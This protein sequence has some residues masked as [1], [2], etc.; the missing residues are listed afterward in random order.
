MESSLN[1]VGN[2]KKPSNMDIFEDDEFI[3][4]ERRLEANS[5]NMHTRNSFDPG[6]T[7]FGS[8]QQ[9]RT[10][11]AKLPQIS[12]A[13]DETMAKLRKPNN[14]FFAVG[15]NT[16]FDKTIYERAHEGED[17]QN[18]DLVSQLNLENIPISPQDHVS[19]DLE[20]ALKK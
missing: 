20:S 17:F 19:G 12:T 4:F 16:T 2:T 14:S 3:K 6:Q 9:F 5:R 8:K 11:D 7:L 18:L 13:K 10:Q 15:S 1:T